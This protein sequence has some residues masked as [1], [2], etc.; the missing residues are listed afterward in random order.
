M[1][2]EYRIWISLANMPFADEPTWLPLIDRLE[3]DHRELGSIASWDDETTMVIVLA[4]DQPDRATAAE[5]A[6]RIVSEALHATLLADR[7]PSVFQVEPVADL[8]PV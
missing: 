3:S 6:A 1:S 2:M 7:F 8:L 5:N 4:D